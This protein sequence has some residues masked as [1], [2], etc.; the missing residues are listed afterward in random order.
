MPIPHNLLV[1]HRQALGGSTRAAIYRDKM[2]AQFP[3]LTVSDL[4]Q[5][6][7]TEATPIDTD[8]QLE[9][10]IAAALHTAQV[11]GVGAAQ[12]KTLARLSVEHAAIGAD[13]QRVIKQIESQ[14]TMNLSLC[15]SSLLVI[16]R[17]LQSQ[18]SVLQRLIPHVIV[19]A[20]NRGAP[21]EVTAVSSDHG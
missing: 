16:L 5:A 14:D 8:Q 19:Y 7:V 17:A 6:L 3:D 12:A 18:S 11:P 4:D 2:L 20:H 10:I 1:L 21:A 15:R 9:H 13:V